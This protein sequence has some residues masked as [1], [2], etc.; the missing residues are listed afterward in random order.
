MEL[1]E[2]KQ[3]SYEIYKLIKYTEDTNAKKALNYAFNLIEHEIPRQPKV[4]KELVPS[5]VYG[6]EVKT[7]FKCPTC[8]EELEG[9]EERC[10]NCQQLIDWDE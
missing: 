3:A 8:N 1:R 7:Y 4:I 6:G 2:I 5:L 10:S 9:E